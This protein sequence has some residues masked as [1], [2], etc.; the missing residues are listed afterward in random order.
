MSN[1]ATLILED[2]TILTGRAFGA[3]G[4]SGGEVCFNTA[5][6]GYQEILTD[7]SYCGQIV[8][9]TAPMIGNVGVNDEDVESARPW[10]QGFLVREYS[11][12]YSNYR[13]QSSLDEYLERHGIVAIEG[14][15]TRMLTRRLRTD[16]AMRGFI[17][18][19]DMTE[20]ELREHVMTVPD[21]R[22]A[23][24]AE[25]VS[26]RERF[27][28][29]DP[30]HWSFTPSDAH[31][32]KF[33]VAVLDCGVKHNILRRLASWGCELTVHPVGTTAADILTERPDGIF[34]SNG[35]GDPAAV[36][37]AIPEVRAM[38]ESGTPLFG[39]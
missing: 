28:W 33:R 25:T 27:S 17:T 4:S 36:T 10:V 13:G 24:L 9:M 32:R 21:M 7:P 38:A 15:D 34:L 18:T 11:R 8:A 23:N 35:P 2:G 16:G 6:S 29:V 3:R 20:A 39:I 12:V 14:I 5:M 31:I 1:L 37:A 19:D 26:T 30:G 22:G